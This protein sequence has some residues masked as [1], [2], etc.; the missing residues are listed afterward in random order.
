[1]QLG[2]VT[3]LCGDLPKFTRKTITLHHFILSLYSHK[4]SIAVASKLKLKFHK[5][6]QFYLRSP[7]IPNNDNPNQ[8]CKDDCRHQSYCQTIQ[9]K[10]R[11]QIN[12]NKIH[13]LPTKRITKTSPTRTT[14]QPVECV[15]RRRRRALTPLQHSITKATTLHRGRTSLY[16]SAT[17]DLPANAG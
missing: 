13:H 4:P 17:L 10:H 1:M 5:N 11:R 2:N 7:R 14:Q 16:K 12:P 9:E 8:H 15:V 3:Q 6:L